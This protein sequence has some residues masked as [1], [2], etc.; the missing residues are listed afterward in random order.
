[1]T[2]STPTFDL[3]FNRLQR[4]EAR[5][6]K[7]DFNVRR[8]QAKIDALYAEPASAS[9]DRRIARLEGVQYAVGF[10]RS[11]I[12]EDI[13]FF[14]DVLPKDEFKFRLESDDILGRVSVDITDSPYDDTYEANDALVLRFSSST[15]CKAGE[16]CG[17]KSSHSTVSFANGE[18]WTAGRGGTQTLMAGNSW[19]KERIDTYDTNTPTLMIDPNP[20]LPWKD[21]KDSFIPIA[22]E[23]F[24]LV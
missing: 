15:R 17:G 23:T 13:T 24:T 14:E 10:R 19:W 21:R 8:R 18:Y 7:L 9:R 2:V 20:E 3:I 5:L 12:V 16:R 6:E 11:D 4:K 1:M 22:T